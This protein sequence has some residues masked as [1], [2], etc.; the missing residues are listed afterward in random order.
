MF[1]GGGRV[2]V[3]DASPVA[4]VDWSFE[5]CYSHML[6]QQIRLLRVHPCNG[7]NKRRPVA[8]RQQYRNEKRR[9]VYGRVDEEGADHRLT[10]FGP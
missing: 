8:V 5:S 1:R 6:R 7:R 10:G 3:L 9:G 2:P 4:V